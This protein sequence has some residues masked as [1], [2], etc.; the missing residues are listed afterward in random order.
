[1]L[2]YVYTTQMH[3]FVCIFPEI[4]SVRGQSQFD[5]LELSRN[6]FINIISLSISFISLGASKQ[7]CTSSAKLDLQIIVDSSGSVGLDHFKT[8]MEVR[9]KTNRR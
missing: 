5:V 4:Y 7:T 1:M 2:Y 3:S 6:P 8:M 9:V